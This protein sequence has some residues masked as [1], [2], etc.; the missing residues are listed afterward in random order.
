MAYSLPVDVRNALAPGDWGG[1][2]P[3]IKTG[4]AADLSDAQ[5]IDAISE[6]DQLIDT[7]LNRWYLTPVA[8][9]E[10]S[11]PPVAPAQVRNWSRDIAAYNATLTYRRGKDLAAYDPVVLR[12]QQAM[13]SLTAVRDGKASITLPRNTGDSGAAGAGTPINQYTGDL[14]GSEDFNL[15]P[16]A[17]GGDRFTR[18]PFGWP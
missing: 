15:R 18:W 5:L 1:T 6:A 2:N 14:F 16:A 17:P 11:D 7:Y 13:T 3:P 4:T 9:V 12:Y 8:P 10:G